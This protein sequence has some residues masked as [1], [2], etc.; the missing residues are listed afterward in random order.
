M[1]FW[2]QSPLSTLCSHVLVAVDVS[3]KTWSVTWD[4]SLVKDTVIFLS[5]RIGSCAAVGGVLCPAKR[6]IAEV[7]VHVSKIIISWQQDAANPNKIGG[8][9][10]NSSF[11]T[12][13]EDSLCAYGCSSLL[14]VRLPLRRRYLILKALGTSWEAEM[15]C[16]RFAA[17]LAT[18]I[19]IEGCVQHVHGSASLETT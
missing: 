16:S 9:G 10:T 1:H 8:P 12:F 3:Q 4:T 7:G 18:G 11:S 2:I 14:R 19:R 6:I 15:Q 17:I 5:H 13:S